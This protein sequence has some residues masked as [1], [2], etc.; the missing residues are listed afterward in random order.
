MTSENHCKLADFG[1][2]FD[3]TNSP[4]SRAIEGDS[5]YLAPELMQ[6]NYSLANDIFSLGIT[7]LELASGLELPTNGELWQELRSLVLPEAAMSTLSD[8]LQ[9]TIRSMMEPDPARRPTV[10]QLLQSPKLRAL[11]K[12]RKVTKAFVG[13]VSREINAPRALPD[14]P[15]HLRRNLSSDSSSSSSSTSS[16]ASATSAI[17]GS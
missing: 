5:R 9:R 11:Q 15:F 2:V 1:L 3:L 7:L 6:G 4:R 12:K 13:S 8:E 10:H 14:I 16:L 17:S